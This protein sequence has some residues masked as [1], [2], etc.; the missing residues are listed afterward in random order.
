MSIRKKGQPHKGK[1]LA[2]IQPHSD[3]VP[4]FAAGTVAK[5]IKEG[6][7]G[8]LIHSS[9]DEKAGRGETLG[10][11]IVKN[12]KDNEAVAGIL[13]LEKTFDLYNRNHQMDEYIQNNTISI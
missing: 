3:D 5:L 13:G 11:V 4:L 8:Y 2:V 7:K 6:Y 12:E 10:E 1:V 9:N